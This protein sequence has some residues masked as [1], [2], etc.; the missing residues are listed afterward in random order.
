MSGSIDIGHFLRQVF[1]GN[2][3][4]QIAGWVHRVGVKSVLLIGRQE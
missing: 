1:K 2:G 4:E 3:L